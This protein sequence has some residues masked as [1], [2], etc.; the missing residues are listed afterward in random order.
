[1]DEGDWELI[2]SI[3]GVAICGLL[4]LATVIG[5]CLFMVAGIKWMLEYLF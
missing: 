2:G 5:G 1:M 4:A 3:I